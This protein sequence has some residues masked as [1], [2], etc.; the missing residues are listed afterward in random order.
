MALANPILW[1]FGLFAAFLGNAGEMELFTVKY[2]DSIFLAV[3]RGI[4]DSGLLSPAGLQGFANSLFVSP[5]QFFVSL[6]LLFVLVAFSVLLLWVV[7][8]SI[9]VLISQSVM[10]SRN[11]KMTW[12]ESWSVGIEKF[13]PVFGLSVGMRIIAGLLLLILGM[14]L[15]LEFKGAIMLYIVVFNL[16]AV[17]IAVISFIGKYAICGVVLKNWKL[18][19]AIKSAW[20]LFVK[21]WLLSLEVAASLFVIYSVLGWLIFRIFPDLVLNGYILFASFPFGLL[22]IFTLLVLLFLF[23]QIILAIFQWAVWSIVFELISSDRKML[24]SR[25]KNIF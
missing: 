7:G 16:V 21:N 24:L 14:V 17:A 11:Q 12:R 25:L 15:V 20:R 19:E 8:V 2:R 3:W 6:I 1:F 13:W 10:I 9:V 4:V 18:V 22:F 5:L 23:V